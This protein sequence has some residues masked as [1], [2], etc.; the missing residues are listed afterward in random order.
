MVT[1]DVVY[2]AACLPRVPG[3][4]PEEVVYIHPYAILTARVEEDYNGTSSAL[5]LPYPSVAG[6]VTTVIEDYLQVNGNY[7]TEIWLNYTSNGT[8]YKHFANCPSYVPLDGGNYTLNSTD[9]I[10]AHR[11]TRFRQETLFYYAYYTSTKRYEV[12]LTANNSMVYA[13]MNQV[14]WYVGFPENKSIDGASVRVYD[15]NNDLWLAPAVNYEVT[16]S[17]IRMYWTWL[18]AST[19]RSFKITF[20]DANASEVGLAIAYVEDYDSTTYDGESYYTCHAS[21]TNSFAGQ[22]VGQLVVR[23]NFDEAE[24]IDSGSL[25]IIDKITSRELGADEF[26]Y[27]GT[28]I[29]I[30]Q[31]SVGVGQIYSFDVYFL[32]DYEK[33]DEFD[34]FAP[35]LEIAGIPISAFAFIALGWGVVLAWTIAAYSPTKLTITLVYGS[36]IGV[37]Y[38]LNTL[39]YV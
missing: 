12:T 15:L 27:A 2:I 13:D 17:G 20:Y 39:G 18:N 8:S 26:A 31:V 6:T 19:Y 24:Y 32:L 16:G 25:V 23:L 5:Y 14:Y 10:G 28:S 34:W 37:L 33:A 7:S 36:I 21:W 35:V 11:F 3:E 4:T 22:Y 30:N 1:P 38:L 29:M 9:T